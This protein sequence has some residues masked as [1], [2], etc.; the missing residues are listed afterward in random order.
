LAP[1]MALP[2][3]ASY[4]RNIPSNPLYNIEKR[5]PGASRP[6]RSYASTTGRKSGKPL[7][8][9]FLLP[10][11]KAGPSGRAFL[12]PKIPR[13]PPRTRLIAPRHDLQCGRRPEDH[14]GS[15][16]VPNTTCSNGN[17]FSLRVLS[18]RGGGFRHPPPP[19]SPEA[20]HR[21]RGAKTL[22]LLLAASTPL[23]RRRLRHSPGKGGGVDE[24][25]GSCLG[26]TWGGSEPPRDPPCAG[27]LILVHCTLAETFA[28][29]C[30][31]TAFL[32]SL[33]S[34]PGQGSTGD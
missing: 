17:A 16:E 28:P 32:V 25:R 6:A 13:K 2:E 1:V 24:F 29:G 9:P 12:P 5:A 26:G 19:R 10:P 34:P 14:A 8:Q 31:S 33:R 22:L 11:H 21:R 15:L 20:G 4:V 7:S 30:I 27:P 18:Q 3:N 23:G